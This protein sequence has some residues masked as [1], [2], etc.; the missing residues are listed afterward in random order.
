MGLGLF[1]TPLYLNVKCLAFSAFLIAVYWM[2]PWAP[3]LS[4]YDLAW[5][6]AMTIILAFV[7]YILLAWYDTLYDCNDRLRPTFLGW[8]SAPF[9]PATYGEEFDRLPI[10]WKK[11]IRTVDVVAVI[12]AVAFVL[13]PFV[14][15]SASARRRAA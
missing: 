14:V 15:Y 7:G 8:L 3:L 12:A 1:G 4:P 10:K 2:P 11:I 9:K 13:S 5:K 6:R